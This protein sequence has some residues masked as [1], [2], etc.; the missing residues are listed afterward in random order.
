MNHEFKN[1]IKSRLYEQLANS[2]MERLVDD[3]IEVTTNPKKPKDKKPSNLPTRLPS[4][5]EPVKPL[6][7]Y[8]TTPTAAPKPNRTTA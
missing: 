8:V 2:L 5:V 7:P 3:P 1:K 6:P 4:A